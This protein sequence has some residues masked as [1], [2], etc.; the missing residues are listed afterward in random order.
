MQA[1]A[2]T[3]TECFHPVADI[4][5]LMQGQDFA[6][7]VADI[8]THGLHESI[9]LYE[10]QVLDG[11]NRWRACQEAGIEPR[12]REYEGDDPVGFVISLNLTRR[13]LNESQRA[14]VGA[15]VATM[16]HG[17]DRK[18]DQRT[19]LSLDKTNAQA[20]EQLNVSAMSIKSAK[21]VQ[22]DGTP[23]L[24][25]KVEAGEVKVSVASDIATLP[26]EEQA[27]VV[28]RGEKEILEAAKAIRAEKSLTR[29]QMRVD[30]ILEQCNT[31]VTLNLDRR[32]PVILADPPWRYDFSAS[33]NREV[34][35]HYPTMAL[36]DIKALP[37][38]QIST[39]DAVLLLWATNPK[40]P[41]SLDVMASWGFHFRTAFTWDKGR[42]GM[43]YWGR[44][45]T[46]RLL[47]GSQDSQPVDRISLEG[48]GE[49]LF[50]T[51]TLLLGVRGDMPTPLPENRPSDLIRGQARKH[52][53]KPD[54]AYEAIERMFP[55]YPKIELFARQQREGWD[56]YGYEAS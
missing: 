9:W 24:V 43:G 30:H 42:I 23:E 45:Q 14:M 31:D 7:L 49:L 41:E 48:G 35:N 33:D 34:E 3:E 52:S 51:D 56:V 13:H 5:P 6:D 55:E 37:V 15:K 47:V 32:Y 44:G 54:E 26:K 8:R 12:Y 10:D 38:A 22:K 46:E 21:H 36:E 2:I 50:N 4:F 17:G 20:A 40:L 19:N 29:R 53:Q 1:E 11:R 25:S 39:D 18:S 27:E 16:K 28:A